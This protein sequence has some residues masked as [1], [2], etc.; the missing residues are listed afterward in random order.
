MGKLNFIWLSC[1]KATFLVSKKEEGKLTPVERI[2]LKM[3][4]GICDFCTRF[5]KQSRLFSQHAVDAQHHHPVML[6]EEKKKLIQSLLK[7]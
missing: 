4:L 3:H 7:D 1:K 5:Q 2:Q 6:S